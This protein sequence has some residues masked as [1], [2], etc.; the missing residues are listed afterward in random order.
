MTSKVRCYS[1]ADAPMRLSDGE[2]ADALRGIAAVLRA[3][4]AM[5]RAAE[6]VG[7]AARRLADGVSPC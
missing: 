1:L 7:E 3:T 5:P 6:A 2:L 4:A